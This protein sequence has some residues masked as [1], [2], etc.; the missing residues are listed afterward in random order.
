SELQGFVTAVSE[1]SFTILGVTVETDGRTEY[2][3]EQDLP[4]TAAE[5]F[6]QLAPGRLVKAEGAEVAPTTLIAEEV[7]FEVED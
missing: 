7:Q 5:F 1:P 6:D 3:D 4:I 2:R